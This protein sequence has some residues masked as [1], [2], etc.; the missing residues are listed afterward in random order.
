VGAPI[1]Y[2]V[3]AVVRRMLRKIALCS[4]TLG[5]ACT[6]VDLGQHDDTP[7]SPV[8]PLPK[9]V[10]TD[11]PSTS[12]M[13]TYLLW[14]LPRDLVD[15]PLTFLNR[16]GM[17]VERALDKNDV[18]SGRIVVLGT[19]IVLAVAGAL[20]G[21]AH[22]NSHFYEQVFY[23]D[24]FGV[25]YAG[26]GYVAGV[27]L[28]AGFEFVVVPVQTAVLRTG[29]DHTYWKFDATRVE[30]KDTDD[31]LTVLVAHERSTCYF[32]NWQLGAR[33]RTFALEDP[34]P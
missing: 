20:D 2:I 32:P 21:W 24:A 6:S 16:T 30:L 13:A 29:L 7:P 22:A 23:A 12:R 28:V 14:G 17:S 25:I 34:A 10:A 4:L 26:V 19:A 9:L 27:A 8:I 33:R 1:A 11:H 3:E 31:A 5:A 15:L 18:S